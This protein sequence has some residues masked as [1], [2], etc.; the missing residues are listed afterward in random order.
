MSAKHPVISVTGSSGAGTTSVKR[1]F[2]QILRRENVE[3]AFIEGDAFHRYDRG[4]MNKVMAEEEAKG[5]RHFSHFGPSANLLEELEAVFRDYGETGQ[6]KTRHYVHDLDE[7]ELYSA[8]PGTFTPWEPLAENTDLLFYEGLHGAVVT[9]SINIARHADLKI[10]VVPVK[11][12]TATRQR[13][14]IQPSPS[15][16]QSC[17]E[18]RIMF[19]TSARNSPKPTLI[20]SAFQR[21]IHQT[22]LPRA[23]FRLPMNPWSLFGF[24]RHAGLIFPICARCYTI[25]TCR[26]PILSSCPAA[27]WIW[28]CN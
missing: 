12:S 28:Q 9:D 1:T 23:G 17:A 3:A 15:W 13:A 18:C 16:T 7:A 27:S 26:A 5:N 25:A 20:S 11:R 21:S 4:Q 10:G 19:I 8:A 6:A 24:A 14:D 2:E 22:H